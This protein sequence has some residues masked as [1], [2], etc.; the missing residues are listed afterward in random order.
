MGMGPEAARSA[1]LT[2]ADQGFASVSNFAVGVAVARIAGA[3]GLGAFSLAYTCW[4][5]FTNIHRG[6]ITDPMAIFGDARS[7]E[8]REQIR[9]GFAAEVM[10]GIAA[11]CVLAL[12]GAALYLAGWHAFGEGLLAVA[13][14][15]T[16]LNLQDYWRWIGFMQRRPGLSLMNDAVFDIGQAM[17]FVAVFVVGTHA[18]VAV[19]SAW[20]LGAAAGAIYGL[21]QFSVRPSLRGGL[22]L[23]KSRWEMSKWLV[24]SS[25]TSWGSSSLYLIVLG[26]VLGPV[27]LGG[28]RAAQALAWGPLAIV[29][30]AGTSFGLPEAS[31]ALSNRGWKGLRTV[32]RL[33]SGSTF[34]IATLSAVVLFAVGGPLL[35]LF[36]GAS[37]GRYQPAAV[38]AAVGFMLA[39]LGLGPGLSLKA[40]GR[41]RWLFHTQMIGLILS[42]V[43]AV[44][45]GTTLGVTGAAATGIVAGIGLLVA[46]LGF[47]RKARR[48][49][50]AGTATLPVMAPAAKPSALVARQVSS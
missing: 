20:G 5:L 39:A 44:V 14:W 30:Q 18:V 4:I 21:R 3:A 7:D 27:G 6:L 48:S 49:I 28:L 50:E 10:L 38:L 42:V 24:S 13:P 2:M 35:R 40:V 9:R 8:A 47:Q 17:A 25:L 22:T 12:I 46:V 31:R 16:F 36:Y 37:F 26:G 41:A 34:L 33:V 19:V 1:V 29:M 43:A 32:S 45:L 11:T 23:L 15:V